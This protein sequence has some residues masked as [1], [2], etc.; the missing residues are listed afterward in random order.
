MFRVRGLVHEWKSKN[1]PN[2]DRKTTMSVCVSVSVCECECEDRWRVTPSCSPSSLLTREVP[3][4]EH[5]GQN[6]S[7]RRKEVTVVSLKLI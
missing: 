1:S 4:D 5:G 2:K 7:L 6:G 3:G